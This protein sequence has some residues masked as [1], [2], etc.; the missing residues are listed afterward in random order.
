MSSLELLRR[1]SL[2]TRPPCF[3]TVGVVVVVAVVVVFVDEDDEDELLFFF[4]VGERS[5]K[6]NSC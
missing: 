1:K 2:D 4:F 3:L 6:T 5:T